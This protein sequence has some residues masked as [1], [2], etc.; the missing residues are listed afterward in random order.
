MDNHH[1][2]N[3]KTS[4]ISWHGDSL[5]DGFNYMNQLSQD[6]APLDVLL[7]DY[8]RLPE[9][10][11]VNPE[12]DPIGNNEEMTI[13]LTNFQDSNGRRPHEWWRVFVEVD[14]GRILNGMS[15]EPYKVF[16]V[17]DGNV[18][19]EYRSP[20]NCPCDDKTETIHI[21]NTCH[22]A[23]IYYGMGMVEQEIATETFE[24]VC[25]KFEL[26][27]AQAL[28]QSVPGALQQ[29]IFYEGTVKVKIDFQ[30]DPPQLKGEGNLKISGSGVVGDCHLT[31]GGG[32]T[33]TITGTLEEREDQPPL[34]KIQAQIN[35]DNHG[36]TSPDCEDAGG[37][38]IMPVSLPEY[39]FELSYLDGE[40][41][42]WEY[43]QP[44]VSGT[45]SWTLHLPCP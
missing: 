31:H 21:Y 11:E 43:T 2:E 35:I 22:K 23:D 30:G 32:G 10:V 9:S 18:E 8:E 33:I 41:Y 24:I 12:Q 45:S 42:E 5:P 20:T 15:Y 14:Q 44:T 37:G 19:L 36:V 27:F 38:L 25:D 7:H 6:F 16:D 13:Q 29:D 3:V 17:G 28:H 39:E 1:A 26:E 34:L 40:G 4:S